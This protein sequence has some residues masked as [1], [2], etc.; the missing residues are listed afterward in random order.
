MNEAFDEMEKAIKHSRI[1][2]RI[3]WILISFAICIVGIALWNW[4]RLD[5]RVIGK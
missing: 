4:S 1:A 3:C 2:D 5:W